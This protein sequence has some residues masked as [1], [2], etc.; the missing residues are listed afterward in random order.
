M[1]SWLNVAVFL[2]TATFLL[3]CWA[4]KYVLTGNEYNMASALGVREMCLQLMVVSI[5]SVVIQMV[6]KH[7][8]ELGSTRPSPG[9]PGRTGASRVGAMPMPVGAQIWCWE[10]RTQ[11][12]YPSQGCSWQEE[13]KSQVGANIHKENEGSI[14]ETIASLGFS[15]LSTISKSTAEHCAFPLEMAVVADS[16]GDLVF[17]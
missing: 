14:Q 8:K 13:S 9:P 11:V 2:S 16:G 17:M 1:N 5:V 10:A 4:R 15:N 6:A 7:Y 3:C 12:L